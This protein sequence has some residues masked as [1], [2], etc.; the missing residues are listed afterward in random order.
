MNQLHEAI[1]FSY[2]SEFADVD[3][4]RGIGSFLDGE[5]FAEW[6]T[7]SD[8]IHRLI[9]I[10]GSC[11]L[12][13]SEFFVVGNAVSLEDRKIVGFIERDNFSRQ[14]PLLGFARLHD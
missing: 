14:N 7:E 1:F 3:A 5:L 6:K 11:E 10:G 12:K 9:E 8:Q 4:D 2:R 13:S